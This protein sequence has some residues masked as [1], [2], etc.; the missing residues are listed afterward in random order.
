M[1]TYNRNI[2]NF[3]TLNFNQIEKIEQRCRQRRSDFIF[4]SIKIFLGLP[5][6][7][8]QRIVGKNTKK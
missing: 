8:V 4:D 3:E 1:K 5:I 6:N 7:I 2:E